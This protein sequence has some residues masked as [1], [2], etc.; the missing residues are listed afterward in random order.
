M[1][2]TLKFKGVYKSDQDDILRSFYFPALAA[3]DRYDRAVGYFSASSLSEAAQALTIFIKGDGLIRL[4]VGAFTAQSDIDAVREGLRLKEVS[5]RIGADLLAAV[6]GVDDELFQHRFKAL[7]WL[8]AHDRLEI[9]VALRPN[10]IYHD[11]VGIITDAQGDAVVFSGSANESAAALLPTHN[12]ES[13]N[14]FP[15]WLPELA[16]WHEPHRESFARLWDNKSRG[17]VVIDLPTAL[18]EN[19]LEVASTLDAPPDSER[20]AQI[21]ARLRALEAVDEAEPASRLPRAPDTIN[22]MPFK[23]REH[24]LE[25]LRAWQANGYRGIFDLATGAGKT[26]TAVYAAVQMAKGV[27]GLAVVI[28][29]PYQSLADQ[30]CEILEA[31][32]IRPLQCYVSKE[33]W[34]EDLRKRVL[35]M[36]GGSDTF[37][38]IVVVNRTLQTPEFQAALGR[39][40]GNRLLWIGD[41]CHHHGSESLASAL[42]SN[43]AY[44]IGLSATPMHYLDEQR[45][46]RLK[47]YYGDVVFSYTLAQAIADKVLTPYNYYPSVVPLTADEAGE[48]ISLSDDIARAF[49]REGK[50]SGPPSTML[51]ALLMKRARIIGSAANKM[52]AL[53]TTLAEQP[54]Q[55]HA[56]FYCGDGQVDMDGMEADDGAEDS[57]PTRQIEAVSRLLDGQ[58]WKVS[59][60]TARESRR[61]R[62]S[63]LQSFKTG[64]IDGLVAIKCLDEGIDVPACSI[65]Y[66]LA[67]SRDP[68]QFIQRRGRILRRSPGKTIANIHDYIVVL[69]E[70]AHD[71]SGA[72][73]KLI[74]AELKRVAEFSGLAENR[75]E[76]YAALRPI[77]TA[78]DLEHV[79]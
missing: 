23:M 37:Q 15:T 31:F 73:R 40:P 14:V 68:R 56:L 69:P 39:I 4:V 28:A 17:T 76:A 77:L 79:L 45:N 48:F 5:E 67:S 32:N 33:N 18:K 8:V 70:D 36:Q 65:A 71:E 9:R 13:I 1:L 57:Q 3:A 30:W 2:R 19:L 20:E 25:A 41:E 38:A 10:G 66:I 43:A 54:P 47:T 29:A 72:A 42:P 64:A 7:A 6:T 21:A 11:K 12:Y 51:T 74:T 24:Q 63:I 55:Q 46:D 26:I 60:F 22:G 78:Y 59:R 61:E 53:Q 34:H 50:S 52:A 44:R 75:N 27:P 62:E 35:D 58:G 49:M 16:P